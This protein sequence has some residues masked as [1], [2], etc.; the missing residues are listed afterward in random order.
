MKLPVITLASAIALLAW[1]G[2][3]AQALTARVLDT[4]ATAVDLF[5]SGGSPTT[6]TDARHDGAVGGAPAL[7][8]DAWY[9]QGGNPWQGGGFAYARAS[10]TATELLWGTAA[11]ARSWGGVGGSAQAQVAMGF[12]ITIRFD[13]P[14]DPIRAALWASSLAAAGCSLG[15]SCSL[16]TDFMHVTS[17]RLAYLPMRSDRRAHFS[18]QLTLTGSDSITVGGELTMAFNPA[19]GPPLV[20][21]ATGDWSTGDLHAFAP[22]PSSRLDLYPAGDPRNAI[23]DPVGN[24]SGY[25]FGHISL[26]RDRPTGFHLA[27]SPFLPSLEGTF[28]VTLTQEAVADGGSGDYAF[29]LLAMDF[30]H[31]SRFGVGQVVDP[32]GVLDLSLATMTVSFGSPVPEP[33]PWLMGLAG[34]IVLAMRRWR[35]GEPS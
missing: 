32:G 3:P 28:K 22:A 35:A 21:G 11:I 23:D 17:G 18:E 2:E 15:G 26:L 25:D 14:A 27:G 5:A 1:S 33:P 34:V 7:Q 16:N 6:I 20:L 24:L 31:T 9:A 4:R 19:A 10:E 13:P 12:D 8:S 29:A 30:A